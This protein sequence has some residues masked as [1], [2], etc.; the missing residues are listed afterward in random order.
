MSNKAYLENLNIVL[1]SQFLDPLV[2]IT[3]ATKKLAA[4]NSDVKKSVETFLAH[5]I[6]IQTFF[7]G[8]SQVDFQE[9]HV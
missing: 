7:G 8:T 9:S 2:Y 5:P 1:L 3:E 6:S 4:F